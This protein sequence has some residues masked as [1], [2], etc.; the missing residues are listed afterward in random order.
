M[1]TCS[2]LLKLASTCI[3]CINLIMN[4]YN[5]LQ[6]LKM[7]NFKSL[8]PKVSK[9]LNFAVILKNKSVVALFT[10]FFDSISDLVTKMSIQSKFHVC[11]TSGSRYM[12]IYGHY[13]SSNLFTLYFD[14]LNSNAKSSFANQTFVFCTFTFLFFAILFFAFLY[15]AFFV[16]CI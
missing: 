6:S 14:F 3:I 12:D 11:T 13:P 8:Q 15:F 10:S 4:Y 7:Q 5:L 16:L 9:L 1:K 2:N